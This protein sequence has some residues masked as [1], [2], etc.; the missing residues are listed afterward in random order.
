MQF[1]AAREGEGLPLAAAA[2]LAAF[3]ELEEEERWS[4]S[5]IDLQ[6][7]FVQELSIALSELAVSN[8]FSR[9]LQALLTYVLAAPEDSG[10]LLTGACNLGH[11]NSG[12][13]PRDLG[14]RALISFSIAAHML[15]TL[16]TTWEKRLFPGGRGVHGVLLQL[17]KHRAMLAERCSLHSCATTDRL[18]SG[19]Q[20]GAAA[21]AAPSPGAPSRAAPAAEG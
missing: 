9:S 14:R 19:L 3:M 20:G 12:G 7:A 11:L 5:A 6:P 18:L 21:S 1:L 4:G 15:D 13:A 10:D 17:A 16:L 8:G 2:V